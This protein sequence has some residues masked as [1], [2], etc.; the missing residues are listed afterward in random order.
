[1]NKEKLVR[2]NE[3]I[4]NE[5]EEGRLEDVGLC[6]MQH[7]KK[8]ME[9]YFGQAK[10]DS[11]FRIYSMT[12]PITAVAAMILYERGLLD[13]KE[14]IWHFIPEFKKMRV[15]TECALVPADREIVVFDLLSMTAG[16]SY[17]GDE[18]LAE[19]E[20]RKVLV[21]IEKELA[22]GK[23]IDL[24][25]AVRR[26]AKCPLVCQPGERWHYGIC[27]DVMGAIIQTIT[28]M[29]YGEFLKKEIFAPLEMQDTGFYL[30]DKQKERLL[31]MYIRYNE[32]GELRQMGRQEMPPLYLVP[33]DPDKSLESAGA[34][35]FST[36]TDYMHFAQMLLDKGRYKDKQ[37]LGRK[38]VEWMSMNQLDSEQCD[39]I[40][41]DSIYGYGYGNFMRVLEDQVV[42]GSN[43]SLGEFGW[44][45]MAGAYFMVD[46]K[47]E[48]TFVYMQHIRQ[49]G[50]LSLRRKM[51]QII[52]G[53]LE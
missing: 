39:T 21:Q 48:L 25:E 28:G 4:N 14:P 19:L 3:L 23:E 51:R 47:E 53:A 41:F 42:A 26:F 30:D 18:N 44:D 20:M 36:V 8:E 15:L 43:G 11:I 5:R 29:K 33:A 31:P 17:D 6:I 37:I 7:G 35:L 24:V 2:L 49:G 34:G 40:Y 16:L 1:M 38:T 45:G 10:E 32:K 22:E 27:A 9:A 52:Y 46:P 13:L 50:D 12:K